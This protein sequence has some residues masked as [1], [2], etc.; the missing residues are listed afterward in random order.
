MFNWNDIAVLRYL[1]GREFPVL[2]RQKAPPFHFNQEP[3]RRNH[4]WNQRFTTYLQGTR[5]RASFAGLAPLF[6]VHHL[7][8]Q[9]PHPVQP[10]ALESQYFPQAHDPISRSGDWPL[11]RL[12]R[13]ETRT[14]HQLLF[15]FLRR[16]KLSTMEPNLF[17]ATAD[18]FQRLLSSNALTSRQL[19]LSYLAQIRRHDDY[20]KAVINT[21]PQD[22]L[23]RRAD[24]LDDERKAGKVRSPLHGIPVL[25]KDNIAT[26]PATGL[27]TTAGSFA[28]V[29]SRPY[30]N[31]VLVDKVSPN[32]P[33]VVP[34]VK[35]LLANGRCEFESSWMPG[36]FCSEKLVY[37]CVLLC[38]I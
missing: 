32:L 2:Q 33:H 17:T 23:L 29:D 4:P 8:H 36:Q 30:E 26:S 12:G 5:V 14:L 7:R 27:D 28:L 16:D 34:N 38:R 11:P 37:R 22:L 9:N 35:A 3:G 19:V 25:L 31:A 20:L 13:R 21:A 15:A 1:V 24:L 6:F 10:T 18:D